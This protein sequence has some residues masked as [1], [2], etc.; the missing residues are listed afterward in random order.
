MKVKVSQYIAQFFADRGITHNFTV[1]GGGAMHLNDSFGH[2]KDITCI[3]NHNEQASAIAAEAYARVAKKIA[4]C[5]V[6]SG[7]G[8]TNAITGVIGGWLD[9]IPMFII[10]GQVKSE[11]TIHSVPSLGLRQL[12]DQE[13]DIIGSVSNMTKYSEI[14][15]DANKIA[16]HLEKAFYLCQQGRPGPVWLD[17]PLDIQGAN[18]ETNDLVH[19]DEIECLEE[20]IPTFE[21]H[22]ALD[23]LSKI[24]NAK[25]PLII[26]GTGIS[27]AG[28]K[29]EFIKLVEK[30]D[31]P[32]V[33]SWNANDLV[34]FDNK[35]FVGM[36]GT[37]GTRAGN[38]CVQNCDLLISLGCRLN[39]RTISYNKLAFA[40]KAHKIIVD[41]DKKELLKPTIIPD[42][43]I[44]A[45]V[46][47]VINV[48]LEQSYEKELH[49][50]KWSQW[51]QQIQNKYCVLTD[52]FRDEA[53][54]I[55]PY[56]FIDD[57]FD[58]LNHDDV[59]A[60]GNGSAC[61][62][63]FQTAKIKQGQVM[64]TNSGCASMG[65]GLP[66]A[67]GAA[68]ACDKRVICIDGDGSFMMN[69]QEMQTIAHNNLN[70]KLF[71]INNSGYLSIKQTQNNLFKPPL[72][73]VDYKSGISFP[74]FKLLA[75]AFGVKYYTFNSEQNINVIDEVLLE[76]GPVLC[77]VIVDEK[78]NFEPKLSAKVLDDGSIVSPA[79]DDMFPFLP[80]DE[81]K[82]I[83]F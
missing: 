46:K 52:K 15:L 18:I 60:C 27:R 33:T 1:T 6:T 65:Y 58:K 73:G 69:M 40:P 29:D 8:G 79:L 2:H 30:L 25:A 3:Y 16:Y 4:L 12:G 74:D 61:V 67:L 78:Q 14:V 36:P 44:H 54:D 9:S 53:K 66:A 72:I 31:I 83:K 24:K 68:V 42:T 5:C 48:L 23:I 49:H 38:F 63:T 71:I 56:V 19:F 76:N 22:Q 59:I 21:K 28:V 41:I 13:F 10:S 32:V 26:A 37:V 81:Y 80:T 45:D 77:E 70:V 34:A 11:T 82:N 55:N 17:I 35:N 47:E 43:A 51:A 64:F 62:V 57:L 20:V 39:I 75:K 7:P 50:K